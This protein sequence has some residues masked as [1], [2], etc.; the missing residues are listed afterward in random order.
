MEGVLAR[1]ASHLGAQTYTIHKQFRFTYDLSHRFLCMG[2]G[3]FHTMQLA[4]LRGIEPRSADKPPVVLNLYYSTIKLQS[5]A[6]TLGV[7][8]RPSVLE[9]VMLPLTPR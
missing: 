9:T 7:E 3:I 2:D 6:P 5:L 8:P 4:A 1:A